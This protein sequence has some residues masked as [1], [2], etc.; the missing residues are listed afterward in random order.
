LY[1]LQEQLRKLII[2]MVLATDMKQHF[3]I[4]G[5]FQSKVTHHAHNST[6]RASVSNMASNMT[7]TSGVLRLGSADSAVSNSLGQ[8]AASHAPAGGSHPQQHG[9]HHAGPSC[10]QT[11]GT[12]SGSGSGSGGHSSPHPQA[13]QQQQSGKPPIPRTTSNGGVLL[14]TPAWTAAGDKEGPA[15]SSPNSGPL[16]SVSSKDAS[17]LSSA[18][19]LARSLRAAQHTARVSQEDEEMKSLHLQVS[20]GG[21]CGLRE[22]VFQLEALS[23][24]VFSQA[25]QMLGRPCQW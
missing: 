2:E 7:S 14:P 24:M 18:S 19:F 22:S 1:V 11:E 13:H 10:L 20:E 12:A 23:W 5:M 16:Q 9:G 15:A 4:H 17:C 3:A 25:G 8:A 6:T 21:C